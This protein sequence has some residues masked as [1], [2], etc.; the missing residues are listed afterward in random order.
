MV[1]NVP[2]GCEI[3]GPCAPNWVH[4]P[5]NLSVPDLRGKNTLLII[6]GEH[7]D[8]NLMV[9]YLA[10]LDLQVFEEHNTLQPT[11][12]VVI[13][14][15]RHNLLDLRLLT[16]S[17]TPCRSSYRKIQS[18]VGSA[19]M[20]SLQN[21]SAYVLL[22]LRTSRR[23][24]AADADTTR[25]VMISLGTGVHGL[26]NW[27]EEDI[28]GD[29]LVINHDGYD[30]IYTTPSG[31][32]A[33]YSNCFEWLDPFIPW[34]RVCCSGDS[35]IECITAANLENKDVPDFNIYPRIMGL[36]GLSLIIS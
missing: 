4:T 15:P 19:Q 6:W 9:D 13:V 36:A 26:T 18:G 14:H 23:A 17:I 22:P 7:E 12:L 24:S 2:I 33:P 20:C 11:G 21:R 10:S 28:K 32:P 34:A 35:E 5:T 25:Q 27:A 3:V 30:Q 31:I 16:G 8:D 29:Q 1:L